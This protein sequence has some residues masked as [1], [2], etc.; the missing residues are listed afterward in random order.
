MNAPVQYTVLRTG[1]MQ[2]L[3]MRRLERLIQ[4]SRDVVYVLQ[5]Y[6]D[7]YGILFSSGFL[8]FIG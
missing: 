5:S 8:Q 4:I 2:K 3:L 1:M 7:A 6:G